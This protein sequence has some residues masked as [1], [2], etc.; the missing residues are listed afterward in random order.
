MDV[1]Q[2]L[3][4][5]HIDYFRGRLLLIFQRAPFFLETVV[6]YL[7]DESRPGGLEPVEERHEVA[8]AGVR[9]PVQVDL[10]GGAA[11]PEHLL[12]KPHP[13]V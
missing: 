5:Q 9:V 12:C 6:L 7:V 13:Q 11:I 1:F 8:V 4:Q 3:P 2:H 10:A